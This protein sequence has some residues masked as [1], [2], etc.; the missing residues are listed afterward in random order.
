VVDVQ[1]NETGKEVS[2]ECK[3]DDR[4]D[5]FR[6]GCNRCV[7]KVLVDTAVPLSGRCYS[8][9]L[10]NEKL[11]IDLQDKYRGLFVVNSQ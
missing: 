10:V 2:E 5:S 7:L 3:L 8:I 4:H 6:V 9:W 11:V 1:T